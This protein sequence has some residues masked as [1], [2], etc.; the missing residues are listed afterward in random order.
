[1]TELNCME[2]IFLDFGTHSTLASKKFLSPGF[3][4][5]LTPSLQST[6]FVPPHYFDNKCQSW[7]SPKAYFSSILIL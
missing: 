3:P 1:M 6:L 7:S 5:S 4:P 2:Y